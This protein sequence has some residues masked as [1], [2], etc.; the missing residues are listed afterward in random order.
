MSDYFNMSASKMSEGPEIQLFKDTGKEQ[1]L[2]YQLIAYI[3]GTLIVLSNLVVVVSSGLILKKGQKPKSTYLLLGNVSLADTIV[4]FSLIFGMSMENTISSNVLC[5]FQIGMLACPV[6]VSL[7]SVG[8]IAVDRYIYILHGLYYGRWFNT[9][10]V[11]IGILCTWI[12]SLTLGFLP[13]TGW[14]NEEL[15]Y[16]RCYYVALFPGILVLLNSVLSIIPIIVVAVLYSIILFRALKN[17][18]NLKAAKND[19]KPKLETPKLRMYRGTVNENKVKTQFCRSSTSVSD[20]SVHR[21]SSFHLSRT[22]QTPKSRIKISTKSKS[23]D[24]LTSDNA[25]ILHDY[26]DSK[27][28]DGRTHES[29]HESK[30]SVY[31][32][33]SN[34]SDRN[35]SLADA[36][37]TSDLEINVNNRS[38]S[39]VKSKEPNK[40]RA[41]TVVM[42]TSGSFIVTWL[43]FFVAVILFVFC[44]DKLKNQKCIE[45]RRLIE[46]PLATLAFVN[47]ILNPLIYAWWHKGFQRSVRAYYHKYVHKFTCYFGR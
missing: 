35:S 8:L 14:K 34:L 26:R 47:S 22:N 46:G 10:R 4:G 3:L 9:K 40:W 41:I 27:N 42:L 44:E 6:M 24:D 11:R 18:K 1:L 15:L 43:P 20:I 33:E 28:N 31:T 7:F 13:A 25:N 37:N 38:N 23:I 29:G 32:V 19:E 45:L 2:K 12:I 36:N 5:I 30:F 21:S 16:T 39:N 17:V